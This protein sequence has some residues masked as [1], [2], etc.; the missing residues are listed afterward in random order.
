MGKLF[1]KSSPSIAIFKK[2]ILTSQ[3]KNRSHQMSLRDKDEVIT[4]PPIIQDA[5]FLQRHLPWK[6][7]LFFF[8]L[9]I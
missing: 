7:E 1:S 2:E 4:V 9:L 8:S 5:V 3:Y 6:M